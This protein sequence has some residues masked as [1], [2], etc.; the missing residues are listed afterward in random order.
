MNEI[1]GKNVTLTS[2]LIFGR[3]TYPGHEVIFTCVARGSMRLAWNSDE[4]IGGDQV[5][6]TSGDVGR[7]QV[8]NSSA[9]ATLVSTEVVNGTLILTSHLSITVKSDC[10]NPSVTCTRGSSLTNATISF[11]VLPGIYSIV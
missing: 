4:Y 7:S 8:I 11:E 6:F 5:E 10:L 2:T 3:I 9:V 1:N